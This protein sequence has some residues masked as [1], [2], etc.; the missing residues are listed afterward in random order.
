MEGIGG[1]K[2]PQGEP[3]LRVGLGADSLGLGLGL[4]H[5]HGTYKALNSLIR[6]LGP[7]KALN[8]LTR[9]LT[10]LQGP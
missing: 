4:V 6:P 9:H 2:G 10:A 1:L 3:P 5:G 7:Y 8:G